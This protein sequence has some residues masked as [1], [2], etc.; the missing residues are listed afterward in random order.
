MKK[1]RIIIFLA[2]YCASILSIWF[3]PVSPNI[4]L[5]GNRVKYE[6]NYS[7]QELE[8]LFKKPPETPLFIDFSKIYV[9]LLSIWIITG[10]AFLVC[11][12]IENNIKNKCEQKDRPNR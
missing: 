7:L 9:R 12:I 5:Q 1:I 11:H 6:R 3:L 10:I 2:M 4:A 8:K